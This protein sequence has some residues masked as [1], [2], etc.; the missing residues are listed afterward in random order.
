M[1]NWPHFKNEEGTWVRVT[2]T[3]HP[4]S[5][6]PADGAF[7]LHTQCTA[8]TT[9]PLPFLQI[10]VTQACLMEDI[11]QWLSTDVVSRG[12]PSPK[13]EPQACSSPT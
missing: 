1:S 3:G 9:S 13:A 2:A 12:P 11:E 8:L 6:P 7:L 10:P 4:A 5:G